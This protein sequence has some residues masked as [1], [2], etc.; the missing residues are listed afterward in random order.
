M[1]SIGSNLD[2]VPAGQVDWQTG[3]NAQNQLG[4]NPA[5]TPPAAKAGV[6]YTIQAIYKWRTDS[7]ES[8]TE[9]IYV[10]EH[11]AVSGGEG[12]CQH[13][14]WRIDKYNADNPFCGQHFTF[15]DVSN[16]LGDEFVLQQRLPGPY[17]Y[18]GSSYYAGA[19]HA[20]KIA[21][22]GSSEK[23]K[24]SLMTAFLLTRRIPCKVL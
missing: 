7:N 16:G 1:G 10:R 4:G 18:Q 8:P 14:G 5:T 17:Q 11:A 19:S 23:I 15:S 2:Y 13:D 9:F 24:L 22:G 21:S 3:W 20:M 12:L 6:S